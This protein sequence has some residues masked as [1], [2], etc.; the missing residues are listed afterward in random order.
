M[1]AA[2][3]AR[4][5][6]DELVV[7]KTAKVAAHSH[8]HSEAGRL[9]DEADPRPTIQCP[10]SYGNVLSAS[11]CRYL[12]AAVSSRILSFEGLPEGRRR[13]DG[14]SV[15]GDDDIS[16]RDARLVRGASRPRLRRRGHAV[17]RDEGRLGRG[18]RVGGFFSFGLR[19]PHRRAQR[20]KWVAMRS[21]RDS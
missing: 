7:V 19:D 3:A 16:A 15:H 14:R 9:D 13:I 21:R 2:G 8:A 6:H 12:I 10:E 4:A 11:P 5:T 18:G 17:G 1:L 20:G